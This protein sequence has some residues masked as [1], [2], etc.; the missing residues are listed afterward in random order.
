MGTDDFSVMLHEF[1]HV[2]QFDRDGW[3]NDWSPPFN[4][5]ARELHQR[6]TK[7]ERLKQLNRIY[8]GSTYGDREVARG[9]VL[10][11]VRREGV[12]R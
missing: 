4:Q 11:R 3:K 8:P 9:Q 5:L 7:G 1:V 6:R 2:L 10:E 12:R